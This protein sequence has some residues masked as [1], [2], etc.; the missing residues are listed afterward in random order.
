MKRLLPLLALILIATSGLVAAALVLRLDHRNREL[1]FA[2]VAEQAST[3]LREQ[4]GQHLLLLA[5]TAAHFEAARGWITAE[6]FRAFFEHLDLPERAP[7]SVGLGYLVFADRAQLPELGD[8]Y[9]RNSGRPLNLWPDTKAERLAVAVL[10]EAVAGESARA[11]GYDSYSDPPRREAI[12]RATASGLPSAT[13]PLEP[14]TGPGKGPLSI[15]VYLPVYASLFGIRPG[16]GSPP[17]PAGFVA[18]V[19]RANA[20]IKAAFAPGA[21]PA[22]IVV[23]DAEMPDLP[24]AEIGAPADPRFG[25]QLVVRDRLD[26]GGRTWLVTSRPSTEF[27]PRSAAPFA[28]ALGVLSLLLGCA[29]AATLR[30]QARAHAATAALAETSQRNLEEKD[31]M[32]QEMKHRIKNA[33]GRILAIARQTAANASDLDGFIQSFTQRLQ[34][35]SNAQDMLTRSRYQRADLGELLRREL[36]QV[37]GADFEDGRLS[38]P[39]VEL[40]ERG[41]QALGLT[42]HELATN[43]LKYAGCDPDIDVSW[44][45]APRIGHGEELVLRWCESATAPI[46]PP[47]R[48]GFGTRLIDANI[49]HELGGAIERDYAAD[50]LR[51]TLSI[52]LRGGVIDGRRPRNHRRDGTLAD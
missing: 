2:A 4:A 7:G 11:S 34:A 43:T 36:A 51:V 24:L 17:R 18:A 23:A 13:G 12:D 38:G 5:A 19:F 9:A 30:E 21:L 32:L 28:L 52:P 47:A 1:G 10:F 50:G 6:D 46:A 3:R 40:D 25:G 44:H 22:N 14:V 37:F 48:S 8:A 35:M 45:V 27:H 39:A 26:V 31:L 29:V 20:F 33:I 16:E 49:R 42:F 15:V 41:A